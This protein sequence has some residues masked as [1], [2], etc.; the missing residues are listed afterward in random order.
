M[1]DNTSENDGTAPPD[2][3]TPTDGRL[4]D[5]G[6]QVLIGGA[7]V[8]IGTNLLDGQIVPAPIR[9]V[10]DTGLVPLAAACLILGGAQLVGWYAR[11]SD[12]I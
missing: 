9:V 1:T 7:I 2:T 12:H 4:D 8:V 6:L 10:L 3:Q 11:R 5:S